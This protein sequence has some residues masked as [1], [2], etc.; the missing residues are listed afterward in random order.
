MSS[1]ERRDDDLP[2]VDVREQ[3]W[4]SPV[5]LIPLTALLIGC[6]L[7][8]QTWYQKGPDIIV[9]FSSAEGIE[10]GKTEV[11][12]K[13][14][15]V[16]K[17]KKLKMSDDLKYI[18]ANIEL[19]KEIGRH[20][21]S[22]ARF[23]VVS[24]R[25]N[26]SGVSGLTTLFSGTYIGMDPGTNTDDL[27]FYQGEDRPPVIAPSENGKRFFL[28][29]DSLGSMDIGAPIFYKQ[30]QV[31]EMIDYKLLPEQDQVRM[32]VFIRD[33][34]YDFVRT[35]TRFWNASGAEFKMSAAGAEFRMESLTSLL[36]GG[37]AF[38]TPKSFAAG[39][40]SNDGDE[41][42]LYSN[43]A[44]SQEK[45]FSQKLYYVMYFSGTVRGLA[46]GAPVEFQGIPVGQVENIDMRMDRESLVVRIPVLVSIQP[47]QFDEKI[48]KDDAEATMRKLVEKGLRAKLDTASLLTGQK[49]ITLSM[50]KDAEP[51]QI[52]ATQFYSEFP[53]VGSALDDLP[54]MA[55][56]IMAS[57]QETLDSVKKLVGSGKLDKTVDN[58]NGVLAEA[59]R[60]VKAAKQAIMTVDKDTLPSV[61]KSINQITLDLGKTLQKIQGSMVQIDRLTAQNSPTQYQL[62][63]MLEELTAASR[64]V[65]SLTETLQRQPT[66]LIRGKKGD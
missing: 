11:R 39:E 1:A 45:Q 12:Y 54:L 51:A 44:A 10:S 60:A 62:Q 16:G 7:L 58:L 35:N 66:S 6:W 5:W 28:L 48:S 49:L 32:E 25:V 27:S 47:Q 36:I 63:E 38:E 53:T 19:N 34:Y 59:E 43:F 33:P 65:R 64:S 21:G 24:P 14:V 31:G 55:I 26:R 46:V 9:Q 4:P 52:A 2:D 37:I 22:D 8:F 17:V 57:L 56:D 15:T 23:W 20:L 50:E 3:R 29:A 30:L 61:N 42:V 41:F 13:A 18:E 40:I